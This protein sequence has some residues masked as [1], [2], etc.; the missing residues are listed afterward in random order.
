M[1][2]MITEMIRVYES[3]SDVG[4]RFK[5]YVDNF[6]ENPGFDVERAKNREKVGFLG[7]SEVMKISWVR[8]Y[9]MYLV[10]DYVHSG[11]F[12]TNEVKIDCGC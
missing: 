5:A 12:G 1:D 2:E 11:I 8:E 9:F 4:R 3:D 7:L 6:L 10:N